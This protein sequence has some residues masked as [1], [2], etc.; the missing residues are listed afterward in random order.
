MTSHLDEDGELVGLVKDFKEVEKC[1]RHK[2]LPKNTWRLVP[3]F[4][5]SMSSPNDELH[6]W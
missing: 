2:L 4:E 6:Q 5:L 3:F 1:L